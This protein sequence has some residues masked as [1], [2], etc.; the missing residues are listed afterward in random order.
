MI[1]LSVVGE[2][3]RGCWFYSEYLRFWIFWMLLNCQFHQQ[4]RIIKNVFFWIWTQRTWT[5]ASDR[6]SHPVLYF[7]LNIRIHII[8][9]K[10][11]LR[12]NPRVRFLF[13]QI[14][15]DERHRSFSMSTLFISSNLSRTLPPHPCFL[16]LQDVIVPWFTVTSQH[17][18]NRVWD[19]MS[20]LAAFF[21]MRAWFLSFIVH[22][23]LDIVD[24]VFNVLSYNW[25]TLLTT[26]NELRRWGELWIR[27]LWMKLDRAH[28]TR[29]RVRTTR[30]R[31]FRACLG[32]MIQV[33]RQT[34]VLFRVSCGY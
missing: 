2:W 23:R 6:Y 31:T 34:S 27:C 28:K 14:F 24:T 9:G 11:R 21:F 7:I 32:T 29:K 33:S 4:Y 18:E 17:H 12:S 8:S 20:F 25:V 3:W 13:S 16:W 26:I 19:W 1:F 15:H 22:C 5:S 30:L 10:F